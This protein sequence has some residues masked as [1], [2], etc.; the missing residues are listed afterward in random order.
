MPWLKEHNPDIDWE[1][2]T[3]TLIDWSLAKDSPLREC[4][5]TFT[6]L[7]CI[8]RSDSDEESAEYGRRPENWAWEAEFVDPEDVWVWAKVMTEIH[9][10][11]YYG[12]IGMQRP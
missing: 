7:R 10:D 4:T 12:E 5:Q 6:L 2:G 11:L 1:E 9:E 8:F 3:V